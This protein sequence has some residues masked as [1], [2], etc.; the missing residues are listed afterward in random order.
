MLTKYFHIQIRACVQSKITYLCVYMRIKLHPGPAQLVQF[1]H[2]MKYM[3]IP[4]KKIMAK[5]IGDLF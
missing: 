3:L 4:H 1:L 5:K 2:K